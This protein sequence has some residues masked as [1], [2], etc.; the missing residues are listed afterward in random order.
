M[1]KERLFEL[2][3]LL[4]RYNYEYHVQDNPTISDTEYD[5]MLREL[6]ELEDKYPEE[7]DPSSPTLKV[8]GEVLDS[9][10]KKTH[11]RSML[12]L[13]N[14]FNR[15]ELKQ[16]AGKIEKEINQVEYCVELKI[17]GLAMSIEYIDGYYSQAVT[18]GDGVVGED[19]TNNVKTIRS[20]PLKIEENNEVEFRGEVFMPKKSFVK[21]NKDRAI[22]QEKEFANCRNAAAGSIR[23][24]DS[25]IAAK[26]GLSAFWYYMPQGVNFGFKTHYDSL[27][28]MKKWGLKV[29]DKTRLITDI[30]EVFKYIQKIEAERFDY[31]YD[32]DGVVIKVNDFEAQIKLGSTAKTPK[33]AIAYKF[34][35]EEATSVIEDIF[36][37]VGRTGRITPNAKLTPVNLAGSTVSFATLHNEDIIKEKDVRINDTVIVKKAGE[38]I[39][40]IVRVVYEDRKDQL[41]FKFPERCPE[42]GNLIY[43]LENESDFYCVNNDCPA[44]IIEGI[45]H[46]A[47]RNAMNIDGLGIKKVERFVNEGLINSFEDIYTLADYKEKIL[48][49]DKFG[50]KSYDNLIKAIEKSKENELDKLLIGLGI[51]QVGE[52][53][54]K[55]LAEKYE[56]IDA[57]M[58]TSVQ[59]LELINDIGT[60]TAISIKEFFNDENNM[61]MIKTFKDLGLNTAYT[62][63]LIEES[64]FGGKVCV[65]TG[66]LERFSRKEAT[67]FLESKG[68]KVTSAVSKNTDYVIYGTSAGSKLTKAIDLGVATLSEE[69]FFEE[70][71]ND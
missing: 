47:S 71:Q 14:V 7:Y 33:W 38:I 25:K 65:L 1:S 27:M 46:F 50:E 45:A 21:V 51:R 58:E 40:E 2:R 41:E 20:I 23:Q 24:L 37:T 9:F 69:E 44:R 49:L 17:D 54:S 5:L 16:W 66:S 64:K 29:N 3:E 52:K 28:G 55:I 43:R 13:G 39:P 36:L 70:M 57:L 32:I 31:S 53:A 68:A 26:R 12:S 63:Q 18:R 62:K 19:V 30:D 56:N 42:C 61:K 6:L 67:V 34:K 35:E 8:G 59:E 48:T 15:E 22:N 4:T 11:K 60:I 10:N